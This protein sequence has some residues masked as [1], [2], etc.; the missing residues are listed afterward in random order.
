M[1]ITKLDKAALIA[2]REPLTAELTA[3]GERLGLKFE[4]GSGTYDGEG[5]SATLKL[6]ITVD[7]PALKEK[8]ARARWDA[9]C[10]YI[11][12]DWNAPEGTTGLRPEDFGT[13]FVNRGVTYRTNG[14]NPGRSKFCISVEIVDGPKK[15][16]VVA[17]DARAVPLI[18]AATDAAKSKAA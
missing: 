15:G 2:L 1:K 11:G 3:L 14:I 5:A 12:H 4:L 16:S 8:S 10:A 17:F 6:N 9:N 7:D 13:E 18:R